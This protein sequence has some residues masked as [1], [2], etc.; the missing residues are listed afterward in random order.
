[1]QT[2]NRFSQKIFVN[3][4]AK[5][6]KIKANICIITINLA[7]KRAVTILRV[8]LPWFLHS[9]NDANCILYTA[10]QY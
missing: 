7:D 6:T 9:Y 5:I 8:K 10:F 3:K 4:N 2:T 1:M